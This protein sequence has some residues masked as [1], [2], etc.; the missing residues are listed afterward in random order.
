VRLDTA[1]GPLPE[2]SQVTEEILG[3]R[4]LGLY[5]PWVPSMDEGW[6]RLVLERFG[7]PYTTLHNADVRAGR[8]R[9]RF[10]VILF[11]SV[12]DGTLRNG[13]AKDTTAPAY[14]G[15]LGVE[16]AD[17]L[18]EFARDGGTIIGLE[19]SCTYLIRE[20]NLPVKNILAGLRSSEFYGPGSILRAEVRTDDAIGWGV[21]KEVSVYFDRSLAFDPTPAAE[22][23]VTYASADPLQSGWLHGAERIRGKAAAVRVKAGAGRV[24]LFGFPPQ[25]RGQT[26]GTFRL[27]FNAILRG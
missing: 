20:L 4:R 21:S 14:V 22:T 16:G 19:D 8:L 23:L 9:E 6:T 3:P 12:T 15:G 11:P 27:L 18:R 2:G 13:Y 25:H 5:Q 10:D 24:I 17:A 7:F 26:Q 1:D